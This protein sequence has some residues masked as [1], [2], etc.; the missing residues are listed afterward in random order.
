MT[1]GETFAFFALFPKYFFFYTKLLQIHVF[2]KREIDVSV[3]YISQRSDIY[4][5]AFLSLK[6][7]FIS[8]FP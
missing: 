1:F 7:C 8:N 3:A 4:L 5:Y 6:C 2:H